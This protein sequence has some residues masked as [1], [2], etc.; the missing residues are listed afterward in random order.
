MPMYTLRSVP[1][2]I[3]LVCMTG[4]EASVCVVWPE[5]RV[6]H[7]VLGSTS[8]GW[9]AALLQILKRDGEDCSCSQPAVFICNHYFVLNQSSYLWNLLFPST[10]FNLFFLSLFKCVEMVLS[11]QKHIAG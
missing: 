3:S 8:Y 10:F 9:S 5:S 2:E 7:Q 6:I 11:K 4:R 1:D